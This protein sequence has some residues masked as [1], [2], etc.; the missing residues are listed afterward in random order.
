MLFS[1]I[2]PEMQDISKGYLIGVG[3]L[4]NIANDPSRK[5]ARLQD[6]AT[7]LTQERKRRGRTVPEG[8]TPAEQIRGFTTLASHPVGYVLFK[9][10]SFPVQTFPHCSFKSSPSTNASFTHVLLYSIIASSKCVFF[11]PLLVFF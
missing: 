5:H 6:T 3:D 7:I 1:W 2:I 11:E 10:P 8:L 9:P 4:S